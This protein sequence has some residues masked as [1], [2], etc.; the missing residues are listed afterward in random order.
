MAMPAEQRP[1]VLEII[2]QAFQSELVEGNGEP[3]ASV[4][5]FKRGEATLT[6]NP[7]G[8]PLMFFGALGLSRSNASFQTARAVRKTT[9]ML[10][11]AGLLTPGTAVLCAVWPPSESWYD[12]A[13]GTKHV[14]VH[15]DVSIA[16][17]V[18]LVEASVE[19]MLAESPLIENACMAMGFR[20]LASISRKAEQDHIAA[21]LS[22]ILERG[23]DQPVLDTW[24]CI[25]AA[26]LLDQ[27][28]TPPTPRRARSRM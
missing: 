28:L 6:E 3:A 20:P 4:E 25:R 18:G 22:K 27:T 24:R 13:L 1:R 7:L 8:V 16:M 21:S 10:E 26:Q 2:Q 11:E 5:K 14:P 9:R 12:V 17:A 15:V 23:F 19:V